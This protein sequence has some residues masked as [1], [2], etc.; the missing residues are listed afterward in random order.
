MALH[1]LDIANV[2]RAPHSLAVDD[3]NGEEPTARIHVE[4]VN[5]IALTVDGWAFVLAVPAHV[6]MV[7]GVRVHGPR[8][9]GEAAFLCLIRR[10]L[11]GR[12]GSG[13]TGYVGTGSISILSEA[14]HRRA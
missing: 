5:R 11:K 3:G 1:A 4:E 14:R 9:L 13:H 8:A 6:V 12:N 10:V 7:A 2:L